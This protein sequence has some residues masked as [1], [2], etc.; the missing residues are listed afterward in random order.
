M[1]ISVKEAVAKAKEGA[2]DLFDEDLLNLR[3]E[4]VELSDDGPCWDIT[5]GWDRAREVSA[6]GRGMGVRVTVRVF[7]VFAVNREN[8]AIEAVKIRELQNVDFTD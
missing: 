3:L 7:K 8:G 4:E 5:L 2:C 1:S 6:L